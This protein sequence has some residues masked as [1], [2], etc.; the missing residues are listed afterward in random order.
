MQESISLLF[1]GDPEREFTA[2][3]ASLMIKG[4]FPRVFYS[5][6][7]GPSFLECA[8]RLSQAV[9]EPIGV[10]VCRKVEGAKIGDSSGAWKRWLMEVHGVSES[11]ARSVIFLLPSLGEAMKCEDLHGLLGEKVGPKVSKRIALMLQSMSGREVMN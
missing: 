4:S 7:H 8:K 11:V 2:H 5:E 3:C 10:V 6:I 9:E 1:Q